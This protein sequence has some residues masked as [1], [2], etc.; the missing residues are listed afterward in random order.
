MLVTNLQLIL[1]KCLVLGFDPGAFHRGA[2]THFFQHTV[3]SFQQEV[4]IHVPL[5]EGFTVLVQ[6]V[7]LQ[8]GQHCLQGILYSTTLKTA[9]E[10]DLEMHKNPLHQVYRHIVMQYNYMPG[11]P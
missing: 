8:E 4:T 3:I 1:N 9:L 11:L 7:L 10:Q 5:L 6:L 2:H